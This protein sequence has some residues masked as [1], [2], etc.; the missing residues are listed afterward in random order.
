MHGT[1]GTGKWK[2]IGKGMAGSL[3]ALTSPRGETMVLAMG[4]NGAVLFLHW[5]T[6]RVWQSLGPA[7]KGELSAAFVDE[8]GFSPLWEKASPRS[9]LP[10]G[11]GIGTQAT[12]QLSTFG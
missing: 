2:A 3:T 11:A 1:L 6:S 12:G 8:I 5:P 9:R 10:Q 7:P 4:R